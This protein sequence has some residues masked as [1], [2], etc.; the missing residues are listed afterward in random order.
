MKSSM[1]EDLIL[2]AVKLGISVVLFGLI[3]GGF[4]LAGHHIVWWAAAII[5]LAAVF[6]GWLIIENW[7]DLVD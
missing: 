7:D 1:E 2:L 5:A 3:E 4:A 6:G